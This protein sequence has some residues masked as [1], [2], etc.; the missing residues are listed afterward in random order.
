MFDLHDFYKGVRKDGIL[1]CFSGPTSQGI[2]EGIGETLRQSMELGEASS[3][4]IYKVFSTFVEQVQNVIYYSAEKIPPHETNGE[5][6]RFGILVIGVK[7]EKFYVRCGN[8]IVNKQ[9]EKLAGR[10]RE[11]QPMD[12]NQLKELYRNRRRKT[13]GP[14]EIEGAGLGLIEMA[15]KASEPLQFEIVPIDEKKSFFSLTTFI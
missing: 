11:L 8:Y 13:D 15:R 9:A 12:K 5:E 7:Q 10:L 2:V 4:T 1:F 3:T 14:N 6:L